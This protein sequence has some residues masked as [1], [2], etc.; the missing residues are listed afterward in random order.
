[1]VSSDT[2]KPCAIC[3]DISCSDIRLLYH[4][5][6]YDVL[7]CSRCGLIYVNQMFEPEKGE[8]IPEGYDAI[9]LPAEEL[10]RVRSEQDLARIDARVPE[11]GRLLDVGCGVGY[12][13]RAAQ[14][15]GWQVAGLDLDRAAV[16]IA[17]RAGLD[18]HWATADEMPFPEATFD[19]VTFLNVVEHLPWPHST[20]TAIYRVLKP[21]GMLVLETPTD[22]FPLKHVARLLFLL[23]GGRITA[24]VRLLYSS[25]HTGGHVYRYS[26]GTVTSL[27]EKFGFRV[28]EILPGEN[29]P[30]RLYLSKRNF[31]K[32]FLMRALNTVAFGVLFAGVKLTGLHSRMVVY[33]RKPE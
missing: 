16:D 17:Q 28:K 27:L 8:G 1:M 24:P 11:R 10:F 30:F 14:A 15:E 19:V 33:A 2:V 4:L 3:E 29:P 6:D 7:T 20:L 18:V 9:Y 5:Q 32:P 22:D 25:Q 31:R 12:L 23:S 21:G 13:L 26:R